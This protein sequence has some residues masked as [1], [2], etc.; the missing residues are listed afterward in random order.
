MLIPSKK[1]DQTELDRLGAGFEFKFANV[2][3]DDGVFEGYASLFG[4]MDNGGDNVQAGAFK[5]SLKKRG[6]GKVKMLF[7][8]HSSDII[9]VWDEISEDEKGL[10]V[11]GHLLL[12]L[13]LAQ[14]AHVLMKAKALDGMSIGFRTINADID[15]ATGMRL[16]K[17]VELWEISIVTFPMLPA[18][19]V[20]A[21]KG[22][23]VLGDARAMEQAYRDGGLSAGDAKIAVSITKKMVQ[24]DAGRTEPPT[25]DGLGDALMAIRKANE[26]LR[27]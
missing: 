20:T 14:Q 11:K 19:T 3:A 1:D 15:R 4:V 8:H 26:A 6:A 9:G 7:Q 23:T 16:L 12:A 13:P 22:E 5:K 25:C 21:V 27:N 24:R 18:A 2:E 10:R 17:E